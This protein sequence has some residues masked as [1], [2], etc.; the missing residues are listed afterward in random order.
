MNYRYSG[1]Q[2]GSRT[3]TIRVF[4]GNCG[5]ITNIV[6]TMQRE[7]FRRASEITIAIIASGRRRNLPG[8]PHAI[9]CILSGME[10][11]QYIDR[12]ISKR[13]RSRIKLLEGKV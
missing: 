9:D 12:M 8:Y 13:Y 5:Q 10:P 1:E 2:R 3:R 4:E 11:E 7:F 6:E